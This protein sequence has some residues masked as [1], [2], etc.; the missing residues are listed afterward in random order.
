MLSKVAR[1]ARPAARAALARA[2]RSAFLQ[3]PA[4]HVQARYF[5][6]ESH[7][8]KAETKKLLSIVANSL[9]TDKEV[10]VRE[11]VSNAS[12]ALEKLRF[13]Q[14]THQL[15]EVVDDGTEL[16]IKLQFDEK[17]HTLTITDT[18][19]GMSRDDL[20]KNL[21][22]IARSGSLEFLEKTGASESKS[23]IIGQFG[24]GFYSVF[25]VADKVEVTSMP[26]DKSLGAGHKWISE[27]GGSY[28]VEELGDDTPR[29]TSIKLYLK[30]D[31]VQFSQQA[32]LKSTVQKF[33]SF[34]NFPIMIADE[35]G[36]ETELNKQEAIWL[37]S[38]ATDE[39]HTQFFQ[40]LLNRSYGEPMYKFLYRTDAPLSIQ[41]V[42]YVPE[43]A[44]SRWE[45]QE[46]EAGVALH[47]RRVLVK[48][49]AD[50]VIPRWLYWVRGVIDCEDMPLN[51]SREN[52]QDSRLMEKLSS[53]VVR[54]ILRFL[55]DEGKK[56]PEKYAKFF[57]NYAYYLK[58]GVLEDQRATNGRHK[59]QIVKLLRFECSNKEKG[60]LISL[61]EYLDSVSDEQKN[62]YY[63]YSTTRETALSSPF[64]ETF[65]KRKRNILIFTDE[66][67]EFL[68]SAVGTFKDKKLVSLDAVDADFE[69]GLDQPPEE[70][71]DEDSRELTAEDKTQMEQFI[72][73]TLGSDRVKKV[74]FTTRLTDSPAV[75]TSDMAPHLRK[76]MKSMMAGSGE[77]AANLPVTFELNAK[78]H[79]ITT[80]S[81]IIESNPDVSKVAVQTLFDNAN[82]AAGMIE[83]PKVLLS[84]LNKLLEVTIYQG[85]GF[86]YRTGTY[87]AAEETAEEQQSEAKDE[88]KPEF[89]ETGGKFSESKP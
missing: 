88:K 65:L 33:S 2:P 59:D 34:V 78:N 31:A 14:A 48:K 89:V 54:R 26:A 57:R 41:A 56:D 24:V 42:F 79:L 7:E 47:S 72:K 64:M 9:Y 49:S 52:M 60:E 55:E 23:D 58:A 63:L 62:I 70:A 17:A 13:L 82:V 67:D 81:G 29:G 10:F 71:P 83:E 76:M 69:L 16:R 8:F 66:I 18:G 53:A 84:R 68:A 39:E 28:T 61:Q 21:G 3:V 50:K 5:A 22:T 37:K 45:Q 86:D 36:E 1:V 4:N 46:A 75:V 12:D 20:V 51:I 73:D 74:V 27:G 11:L 87:R 44:P 15:G 43:D 77:A 85:A 19:V 40:Y 30:D 32:T 35:K 25:V 38:S 6:A 80:L